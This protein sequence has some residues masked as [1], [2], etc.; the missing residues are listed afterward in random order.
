MQPN[1]EKKL[2]IPLYWHYRCIDGP[3]EA[4]RANRINKI[5][6]ANNPDFMCENK[7]EEIKFLKVILSTTWI[8]FHF[9]CLYN[10]LTLKN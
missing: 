3:R 10:S 5:P 8:Q 7:T 6:C 9:L 1:R 2:C 4:K